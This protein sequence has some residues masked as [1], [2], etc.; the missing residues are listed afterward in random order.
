M[1]QL[2]ARIEADLAKEDHP[3]RRAV[4]LSRKAC[5]LAR[6]GAFQD[7]RTLISEL[8]AQFGAGTIPRVS[9][10][11]ML[12]E[13]LL[14]T[15]ERLS[16]EGL[17][18]IVR[19][20]A[21]AAAMRDRQLLALTAG[22]RAHWQFER[23]EFAGMSRSLETVFANA[24]QDDHEAL[25]RACMVLANAYA[26][27][28][29]WDRSF[30]WYSATRDHALAIGDQASIE[31]LIYNRAAFGMAWLRAQACLHSVSPEEFDRVGRE[32]SS[33]RNYQNLTGV[34]ALTD[35]VHL[36]QARVHLL[37]GN[38]QAAIDGLR[39]IRD[40]TPY[41]SYSFDRSLVDLEIAYCLA[42]Q[43]HVGD[44]LQ[45]HSAS[46]N[47]DIDGLHEDEQLVVAWLRSK[48]SECAEQFA[49]PE[50][51]DR[52]LQRA[53]QLFADA[54]SRIAA[55]LSPFDKLEPPGAVSLRPKNRMIDGNRIQ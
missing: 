2:L 51:S 9:V 37:Q 22:W 18:R 35:F 46:A 16:P 17:D 30:A 43:G 47:I 23:S 53:G 28:G 50:V 4:L 54:T 36:W 49:D 44:A 33:A 40:M 14:H 24:N 29:N 1:S 13:G 41:S 31:A 55:S 5:Y 45:V 48:L 42:K 21:L 10:W 20:E 3:T 12:A 39:S 11:I 6:V 26:S 32:I 25:S 15:F 8:R 27:C 38:F 19:A 7:S 52:T 34:A